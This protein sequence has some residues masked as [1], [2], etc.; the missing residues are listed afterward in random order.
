MS[1][2]RM[3]LR[4]ADDLIHGDRHN[5]YGH[6][7]DDFGK[8]AQMWSAFLGVPVLREQVAAM[9]VMVK[10]SRLSNSPGHVDSWVD[11]AGYVGCADRVQRRGRGVE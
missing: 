5:D 1:D 8:T 3:W 11:I 4:V 6:P 9:M 10:L 2:D 7:Y